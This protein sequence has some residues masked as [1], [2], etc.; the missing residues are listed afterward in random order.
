MGLTAVD[1]FTSANAV[2]AILAAVIRRSRTGKGARLELSL[3]E[4]A[5][6]FQF[7]ILTAYL[8]NGGKVQDRSLI[9]NAHVFLGAPYGIYKTQDGYIAISMGPI[10]R[11]GEL[12][13]S[14]ILCSFTN[15]SDWFD[16]RDIIKKALAD[17]LLTRTTGE[18]LGVL[19]PAD[20]WAA[21]VNTVHEMLADKGLAFADMIQEVE[22][23]NGTRLW[24][25]RCPIRV[26]GEKLFCR[27]GSPVLGEDTESIKREFGL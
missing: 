25:T 12:I 10:T 11:L 27:K 6:D 5:I 9:S 23:K 19:E 24:T 13:G 7:E 1:M 16:K 15:P 3:L 8:N 14:D 18:W 22:R 20:F 2:Q 26:D 4:T 17:H 21:K